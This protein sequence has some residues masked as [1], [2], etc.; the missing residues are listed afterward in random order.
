M[1]SAVGVKRFGQYIIGERRKDQQK[2]VNSGLSEKEL[3]TPEALK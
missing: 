1:I 2:I 3:H